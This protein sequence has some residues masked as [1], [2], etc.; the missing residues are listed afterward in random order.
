MNSM[1]KISIENSIKVGDYLY[2]YLE[3]DKNKF[4]FITIS[5]KFKQKLI[6][7]INLNKYLIIIIK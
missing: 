4:E 6:L 2:P 3:K 7:R 5:G 1:I